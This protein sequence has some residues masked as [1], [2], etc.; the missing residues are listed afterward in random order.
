[1]NAKQLK[2]KGV[3][4]SNPMQ[5]NFVFSVW[6]DG[7]HDLYQAPEAQKACSAMQHA[8]LGQELL[9]LNFLPAF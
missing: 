2:R 3:Y 1:M 7:K 6:R 5:N 9:H 8:V 4:Y